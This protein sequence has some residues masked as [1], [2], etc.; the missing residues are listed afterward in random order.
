MY[1][2]DTSV[3]VAYYCPERLSE[4]TEQFATGG[5]RIAISSLTELEFFSAVSRKVREGDLRKDDAGRI[6]A[7]FLGHIDSQFYTLIQVNDGHYRLA[8][9]WIGLMTTSLRSL[10]ALHL[11][12]AFSEGYK[13][14][15]AD[16]RLA[17]SAAELGQEAVLLE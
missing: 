7:T 5:G 4:K 10:D 3:V 9:D 2:L 6:L 17:M 1:Y 13:I 11:A 8:R 15:T 14:V 16:Q 12:V